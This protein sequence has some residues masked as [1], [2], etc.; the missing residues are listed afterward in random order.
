MLTF[1]IKRNWFEMIASGE[2]KEEYRAANGYYD[3]RLMK[4]KNEPIWVALRNGY[5]NDSDTLYC[6]VVPVR[7]TAAR[8][9]WGGVPGEMH[10]SLKI[11]DVRS[12]KIECRHCRWRKW[13][14]PSPMGLCLKH[15]YQT[16]DS[17]CCE[18]AE[19]RGK[20]ERRG[21]HGE[22]TDVCGV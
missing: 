1:T 15:H 4:Y 12:Y 18:Y 2:K 10:W 20:N 16:S 6:R 13:T 19:E 8:P 21:L 3:S 11:L 5:R 9:E 7:E 17:E 22:S 14:Q